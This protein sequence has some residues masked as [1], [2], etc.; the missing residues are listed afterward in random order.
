MTLRRTRPTPRVLIAPSHLSRR[1]VAQ[2]LVPGRPPA[3]QTNAVLI[4][5]YGYTDI[6][7]IGDPG[8][9]YNVCGFERCCSHEGTGE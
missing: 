9:L 5:E 1:I 2:L 3:V 6:P 4:P 7:L 8:P